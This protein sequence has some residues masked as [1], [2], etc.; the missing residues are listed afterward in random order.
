[1]NAIVQCVT[2][3]IVANRRTVP[4]RQ[5]V[6]SVVAR[7]RDRRW[8]GGARERAGKGYPLS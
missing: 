8:K 6:R 7:G 5:L 4:V 2:V 1:M 3:S